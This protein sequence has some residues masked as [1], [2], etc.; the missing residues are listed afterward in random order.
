VPLVEVCVANGSAVST[1]ASFLS[2][3][4]PC[5]RAPASEGSR[6][7][8][9]LSLDGY[10]R[11]DIDSNGTSVP[12]DS[13]TPWAA[14]SVT[15]DVS[16]TPRRLRA[17]TDR[18]CFQALLTCNEIHSAAYQEETT[19]LELYE[20]DLIIA[21]YVYSVAAVGRLNPRPYSLDATTARQFF[22]LL[23][24]DGAKR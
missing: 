13:I 5:D 2:E 24:L 16:A 19:V 20:A 10:G 6:E 12:L 18:Q 4:L 11:Q 9:V 17:F 1:R 22:A 21:S 7:V 15:V 14:V 23:A 3:P 8:E